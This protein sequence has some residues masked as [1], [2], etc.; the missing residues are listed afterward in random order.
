M[1]EKV[2]QTN[3]VD[4]KSCAKAVKK[5]FMGTSGKDLHSYYKNVRLP[6]VKI[7]AKT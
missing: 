1:K 7:L 5:A 4:E 2:R 3:P 6:V